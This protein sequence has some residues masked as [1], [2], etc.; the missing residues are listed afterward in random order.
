MMFRTFLAVAACALTAPAFAQDVCANRGQL[1]PMYCDADNDL[2][3]DAP[4]DPAKQKDPQT[5]IFAYSPVENPAVYQAVYQP[6]MNHLSTCIGRKV[7]NFPVQNYA[8]QI[9]AMRSGRLH[10]ALYPTGAVGFAVNLAGAVPFAVNGSERGVSGYKVQAIVKADSP[11]KS[12]ADLK[13]KRV[14]H[15]APSSNS[16][17]LAPRV[18]FGDEGLKPDADYKPLMSG[19]HDKSVMGVV[20]GDYDMAPVASDVLDRMIKRGTIKDGLV[21]IIWE[22]PL[23][24]TS[25]W[26]MPHDLKPE[27]AKKITDCFIGYQWDEAMKKEYIGENR[28][29]P[30]TYKETW[31]PI[32]EVA[33]KSGTPYN[34]AAYEAQVKREAEAAAKKAAEDG[35]KKAA[36]PA[37]PKQ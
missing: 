4:S 30:M 13:G 36:E 1:D 16:G 3:A 26:A 12:L 31:K 11:F 8:A 6:L 20:N 5:I 9:E 19:G 2:V 29:Y 37:A 18:Y 17:N 34:K 27:L 35:A 33:E 28:F 22:S 32:R 23:F 21:R 25:P 24:P 7:V 14:A 10:I 15:T